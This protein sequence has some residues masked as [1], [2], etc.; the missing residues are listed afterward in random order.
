MKYWP[1]RRL[2]GRSRGHAIQTT[3][4]TL[5]R[6]RCS[7]GSLHRDSTR[8]RLDRS[9]AGQGDRLPQTSHFRQHADHRLT[10]DVLRVPILR[11]IVLRAQSS[12]HI[13]D[14][15]AHQALDRAMTDARAKP[16][17]TF[18]GEESCAADP[19]TVQLGGGVLTAAMMV[20]LPVPGMEINVVQPVG[21]I[22]T[23][24]GLGEIRDHHR[25]LGGPSWTRD[26]AVTGTVV[27]GLR[28]V[29]RYAVHHEGKRGHGSAA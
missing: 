11:D 24:T 13:D 14:R 7:K 26:M 18:R 5:R 2:R 27:I 17:T 28:N 6:P 12:D 10:K 15:Q 22:A 25:H 20:N 19:E 4:R 16:S 21:T 3:K 1:K 9:L 8:H 29:R 23:T